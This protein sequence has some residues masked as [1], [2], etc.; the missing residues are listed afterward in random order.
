MPLSLLSGAAESIAH[1]DLDFV[2]D[3]DCGD[4]L[5]A[6]CS[7][8]EKMRGVLCENN[9]AMWRMLEERKLLQASV[10]HDLR[11]PIAIVGGYAEYLKK[12]LETGEMNREKILHIVENMDLAA[13]RL[14]QYT[15]SVGQLNKS[16]ERV[17]KKAACKSDRGHLSS[18][19]KPGNFPEDHGG[20]ASG[21]DSGGRNPAA[22]GAGE[23]CGKCP[24]LCPEGDRI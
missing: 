22:P 5:G 3:Y 14:E 4:E 24:A 7:S 20:T 17:L 19:R 8:F 1:Q 15:E 16:E 23:H 2:L 13:K 12:G 6:L 11:N 18:G 10:A 21:R 9:K